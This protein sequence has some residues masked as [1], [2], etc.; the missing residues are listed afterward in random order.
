MKLQVTDPDYRTNGWKSPTLVSDGVISKR[1]KTAA[2]YSDKHP[3]SF[4]VMKDGR[5]SDVRLAGLRQ[6]SDW[7]LDSAY[8]DASR[9]RNRVAMDLWDAMYRLPWK[10]RR[11]GA[12]AGTPVEVYINDRYR[13]VFILNE[14]QDRKQTGLKKAEDGGTGQIIKTQEENDDDNSPAGFVSLGR[15]RPGSSEPDVW[16]N[17]RI[18]YPD[19]KKLSPDAWTDF[20]DLTKLVIKGTDE[21]FATHITDYLDLDNLAKYYVLVSALGLSDNM[22]KNMVFVRAEATGK[23]SVYQLIPWDMDA[24]YGRA[25]TSRKIKVDA[26]FTNR[27]FRRLIKGSVGGFNELLCQ[28]WQKYGTTLLSPGHVMSL[29]EGYV[30]RLRVCGADRREMEKHPVFR[31]YM[32]HRFGFTLDFDRELNYIRDYLNDRWSWCDQYFKGLL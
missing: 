10:A 7:I 1:G 13:G 17:V 3:Y 20:Y 32:D 29:F 5:K 28:T 4:S 9:F 25:Y 15:K 6:D 16:Y 11:S 24:G 8:N 12:V 2:R 19:I 18:K 31:F 14:K 27:L 30:S 23:Y 22:R 21:E 26:L